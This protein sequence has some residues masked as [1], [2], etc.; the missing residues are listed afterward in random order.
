[1]PLL[2][3][4]QLEGLEAGVPR[5]EQDAFGTEAALLG[6]AGHLT[7]ERVLVQSVMP[8]GIGPAVRGELPVPAGPHQ[9]DQGGAGDTAAVLAGPVAGHQF[10]PARVRLVQQGVVDH[11]GP[12]ARVHQPSHLRP[13][14][15]RRRLQSV[16]QA[17]QGVVRGR[18]LRAGLHT[19]SLKAA[20]LLLGRDQEVDVVVLVAFRGAHPELLDYRETTGYPIETGKPT[21]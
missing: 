3:P 5:V 11:Q 20:V 21:A 10:D 19:R 15:L 13:Q 12:L 17:G 14:T 18:I 16:Q 7:A 8:L 9:R 1:V 2:A 4:E 6:L